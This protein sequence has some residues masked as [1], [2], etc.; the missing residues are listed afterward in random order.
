MYECIF[1]SS[2]WD[3]R[4]CSFL[5]WQHGIASPRYKRVV[6]CDDMENSPI[7]LVAVYPKGL[8]KVRMEP[9]HLLRDLSLSYL[10]FR[11][12]TFECVVEKKLFSFV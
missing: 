6:E 11:C 4:P 12:K 9:V 1:C 7:E 2:I 10:L 5:R 8:P 3:C